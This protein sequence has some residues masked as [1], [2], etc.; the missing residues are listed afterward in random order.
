VST[1]VSDAAAELSPSG[2]ELDG[3]KDRR[4]RRLGRLLAGLA[5]VLAAGVV[6][7]LVAKPF[8]HGSPRTGVQDNGAPVSH[9][10][11]R[12]GSLASQT[13]VSGT[14]G[15]AG[16]YNVVNNTAGTATWLPGPGQV[17]R[18]GEVLYRV[19]GNPVVLLY[20]GT[21]AYRLLK[22]GVTGADV[23]QLNANLVALGY[24]PSSELDPRSDY[25]G[26][27]TRYALELLQHAVGVKE[28]GELALGQAVFLPEAV[29]LTHVTA[30]L[31]TTLAP[32][33]VIAQGTSTRR[34]V[35]VNLDAAQQSNVRVG[36]RVMIT[37]PSGRA[38]PGVVTGMG[39]V[40]STGSSGSATVPVYIAARDP[41]AAG[42]VDQ[43]PVQVAITTARVRSALIVPVN[44]LLALA[45]GGYAV[46]TIDAR[47]V[48][49]LVSVRTGLF[50]DA[51]GLV[52]VTGALSVGKQIV[53]PAA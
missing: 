34:H 19:A 48:H 49:R 45:G 27:E 13:Q 8:A 20:G 42:S 28:T 36:D 21:P 3:R 33:G 9:A 35:T 41:G 15:Y 50:D 47:G 7:L 37:L 44:A 2:A 4:R 30:T 11:V 46:E 1:D 25:F 32:G 29:R 17:I 40:A 51:D 10:T 12:S 18:R 6:V 26:G 39:K 14:L 22:E 24:A 16:E 5:L 52:Q 43:A 53:V 23:R 38:T 31:G